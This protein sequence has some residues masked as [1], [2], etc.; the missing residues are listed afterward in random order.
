MSA[1]AY[2]EDQLVEQ[3]AKRLLAELGWSLAH[4][5]LGPLPF[6][7]PSP[8]PLPA[9][10]EPGEGVWVDET[11]LFGRETKGEVVLASRLR[12]ALERLNPAL[13]PEAITAAVD[14]LTRDRSAMGLPAANREIY[15]LI[16]DGI[17]VSIAQPEAPP[18]PPAL[19]LSFA[20]SRQ[21]SPKGRGGR[22]GVSSRRDSGGQRTERV[23]VIDW[24]NPAA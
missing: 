24:E 9:G 10:E 18:S 23:R 21:P 15:A 12:T 5:H 2:T 6:C 11:G 7:E 8:Q 1:H 17:R 3:P 13:P 4:P 14:E 16:K 19:L 22:G 20:P